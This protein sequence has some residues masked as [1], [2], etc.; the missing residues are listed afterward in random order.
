MPAIAGCLE[1]AFAGFG[2]VLRPSLSATI[3]IMAE[4]CE[5]ERCQEVK[6]GVQGGV[7]AKLSF[8]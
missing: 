3:L 6:W 7:E 4:G 8:E 2:D 5:R 1:P